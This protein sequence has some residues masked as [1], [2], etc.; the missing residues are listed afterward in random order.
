MAFSSPPLVPPHDDHNIDGVE[1]FVNRLSDSMNHTDTT[2]SVQIAPDNFNVDSSYLSH[3]RTKKASDTAMLEPL[4]IGTK[5]SNFQLPLPSPSP[6]PRSSSPSLVLTETSERSN[7]SG[8]W[9]EGDNGLSR[10]SLESSMS[11]NFETPAKNG[12]RNGMGIQ[13]ST[14]NDSYTPR[15]LSKVL[16]PHQLDDI[17]EERAKRKE[18]KPSVGSI[19]EEPPR[20]SSMSNVERPRRISGSTEDN[21]RRTSISKDEDKDKVLKLSPVKLEE[22]TK[23]PQS[24]P[25]PSVPQLPPAV[26]SEV[27]SRGSSILRLRKRPSFDEREIE[28]QTTPI[29]QNPFT[30]SAQRPGYAIR[31]AS[32]PHLGYSREGRRDRDRDP[33]TGSPVR[34]QTSVRGSDR[35]DYDA[36]PGRLSVSRQRPPQPSSA[37]EQSQTP[38]SPSKPD[39][40]LPLPPLLSTYLQLELASSRPS[41]LYIHRPRSTDYQFESAKLKF[42]RLLNF[43]YVP[44]MLEPAMLFGTLSCLDAWLYTFTI[45]PLR[46][47]KA[48]GI[49]ASWWARSINNEARFIAGFVWGAAPRFWQRQ[50]GRGGNVQG[51]SPTSR[52]TSRAPRS[53][54]ECRNCSIGLSPVMSRGQHKMSDASTNGGLQ[55][56]NEKLALEPSRRDSVK[57]HKRARSLPSTLTAYHKSDIL[58]GFVIIFSCILLMQL[59]ASRMYHSI[60]GQAAMKL[61]VI[62]NVLEVGDRLL[63][64][65]GQDILECLVSLE[66]LGRD[67]TG[68]SHLLRPAGMFIL[69]LIYNVLHATA[70]FYQVITLNVAVNSYS[71][72]LFTLLLS[73]QFVEI[74]GTVFKRIEKTN[75]FQLFCA[76]VVERFQLWLMLVIIGMRNIV[77]VGGLSIVS[78]S[79]FTPIPGAANINGTN[80]P[81]KGSGLIPNAFNIIPSWSGEVLTPFLLVLGSEVFVDW[82]KHMFVAKFNNVKPTLYR[83]FLD[84]LAKDYYSN[85]FADQNLTKR[86]GLP[87][88]PLSCLFIRASVQTYNMFMSSHFPKPLPPSAVTGVET[89]SAGSSSTPSAATTKAMEGIDAVIRKAMGRSTYGIDGTEKSWW[90]WDT[91]DLIAFVAMGAFFLGVFLALLAVKLILGMLLLRW[92]RGRYEE[93]ERRERRSRSKSNEWGKEDFDTKGMRL[94]GLGIVELDDERKAMIYADDPKGY[95]ELKRREK[96]W[97]DAAEK[98]RN[99]GADFEGVSR[100]E[101][102]GKRIW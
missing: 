82:A 75:L 47:F 81:I 2:D 27:R 24:L 62:Y 78:H 11:S 86:L 88:I 53:G 69:T 98:E 23:E 50:R 87:V 67:A 101:M 41:P 37:H 63:S 52:A 72:S 10:H 55:R 65:V 26:Q 51:S 40:E 13:D 21:P 33:R 61:Y 79:S 71:N 25:L 8:D 4:N 57:R 34:R 60:R 83:H 16:I 43:L 66:T 74:K 28:L 9:V 80:L 92:A 15:P 94:G 90:S 99:E 77:E 70:L 3:S 73:N 48:L 58:Q 102:S 64:A 17:K 6:S 85:A 96:K 35:S 68:R 19:P 56:V 42:E 38:I 45:L 100:Y 39:Q 31:V 84:I 91:D 93:V 49:L 14:T 97:A 46:F 32:T 95:Q 59:D 22:L 18:R 1:T 29:R 76:D 20:K 30:S 89:S 54:S 7:I 5:L 12:Q 44:V 36:I